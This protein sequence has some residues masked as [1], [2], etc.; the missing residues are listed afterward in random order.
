MYTAA[1]LVACVTLHLCFAWARVAVFR[2]DGPTPRG[3]RVIEAG[4]TCS[5]VAG[6]ALI[7]SRDGDHAAGD[8]LAG[9]LALASALLFLW[10]LAGIRRGELT[11]AFSEDAPAQLLT[12]GAFRW[13]RHPFYLSYLLAHAVPWPASRSLWALPGLLLMAAIYA[14]AAGVEERKFQAGPLAGAW[15]AYRERT[16][17]LMPVWG[18]GREP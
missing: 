5:A 10:A 17:A 16:R 12:R 3:V 9:L 18:V 4:A 11:A 13:L 8:A 6:L 15:R 7:A 2:I 1:L 14:R